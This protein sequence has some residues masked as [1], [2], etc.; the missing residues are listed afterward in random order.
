MLAVLPRR[1]V[2]GRAALG[3]E[4]GG[5]LESRA[6]VSAAGGKGGAAFR[7][8][9]PVTRY[10][11]LAVLAEHRHCL[12]A[13]AADFG[14]FAVIPAAARTDEKRIAAAGAEA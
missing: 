3:A 8:E 11:R 6:A 4:L 12:A 10:L 1:F 5:V 2:H 7:T 13:V 14:V 9:L